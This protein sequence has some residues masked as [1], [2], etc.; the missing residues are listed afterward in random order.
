[1]P[2]RKNSKEPEEALRT[3]KLMHIWPW[4]EGQTE[5]RDRGR[6]CSSCCSVA[7]L[8]LTLQPHGLQHTRLPCPSLSPSLLKFMSIE[9]VMLSKHLILCCP[10][11]LLSL[12]FPSIR[13]SI[14]V[15]S[16]SRFFT[17]C[18]Q[19]IGASMNI[20]GWFLLG[21]TGLIS[22]LSKGLSRVFSSTTV[23]KK[24]SV[25]FMVQLSH[26]YTAIGKTIALT[27]QNSV[28]KVTSAF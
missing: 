2:V 11:L 17:S 10:R 21:L 9:S 5:R 24:R 28:G 19:S 7:Q 27:I 26:P 8:C 4:V 15:F 13:E 20:Q 23:Q 25:F 12:I 14:R 3:I 6:L 1:M 18:S 22:L 16:M